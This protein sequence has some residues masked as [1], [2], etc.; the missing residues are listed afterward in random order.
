LGLISGAGRG[1]GVFFIESEKF[2]WIAVLF[3]G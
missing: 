3:L 1:Y 2:E